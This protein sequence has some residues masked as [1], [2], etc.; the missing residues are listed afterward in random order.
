MATCGIRLDPLK[1]RMV[2]SWKAIQGF[3]EGNSGIQGFEDWRACAAR[4]GLNKNG[5]SLQGASNCG[6][7]REG[8]LAPPKTRMELPFGLDCVVGDWILL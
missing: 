1:T 7:V 6:C 8:G 2:Q 5:V 4:W 3:L